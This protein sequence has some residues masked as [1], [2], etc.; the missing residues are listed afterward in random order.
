[1]R[2]L[3]PTLTHLIKGL[4][5]F[6]VLLIVPSSLVGAS[7]TF[8]QFKQADNG[9]NFVWN[10]T[11]ANSTLD[12]IA[13]VKFVF[14]LSALPPALL[15]DQDAELEF[16]AVATLPA[17]AFG[18]VLNQPVDSGSF[19]ITRNSDSAVL[20]KATFQNG[21]LSATPGASGA[22]LSFSTAGVGD[23]FFE[24]AFVAFSDGVANDFAFGLTSLLPPVSLGANGQFADFAAAGAGTFSSDEFGQE[25]PGIPEPASLFLIGSGLVAVAFFK[26]LRSA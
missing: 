20:L 9:N 6:S 10:N 7:V 22:G 4:V 2:K 26:K 1:M 3:A 24:S 16:G 5:L 11:G 25:E 13:Q 8:A 17:I 12:A 19:T 21:F 15:V 18:G 14:L 23:V